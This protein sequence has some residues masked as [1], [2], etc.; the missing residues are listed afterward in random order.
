VNV[1]PEL[2][3][4][5]GK[6]DAMPPNDGASLPI[7]GFQH[8]PKCKRTN[9]SRRIHAGHQATIDNGTPLNRSA[10]R[11]D[12]KKRA[13]IDELEEVFPSTAHSLDITFLESNKVFFSGTS[14]RVLPNNH[15]PSDII[16]SAKEDLKVIDTIEGARMKSL[17][18]DSVFFLIPRKDAI[19]K[20]T[21]VNN[22]L[23]S[24]HALD[25]ANA[26]TEVRGKKRIAVAEDDGKYT[27]VGL[28]ANRASTGIRESWPK[29]FSQDDKEEITKLMIGCEEVANGFLPPDELR[30]FRAAKVLGD[31][32]DLSGAPSRCIFGSLASG[33]NH[34]LNTHTDEDFF[35]SVTTVPSAYGLRE[36]IDR[37]QIDVEVC[38]YFTFPEQGIAVALRPGDILLFNPQYQHCISSRTSIYETEDV[39]C[40]SLYLKS[41]VV[42][43]ND[44]SLP[45][46]A[47]DVNSLKGKH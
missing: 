23:S 1:P 10:R 8:V 19:A 4:S 21:Y 46:T 13:K 24:L 35:Y 15:P 16:L 18:G 27:T 34:Y 26:K 5:E 32:M 45:H 28:K 40:V 7:R 3:Y 11:R 14:M 17:S 41:A 44:N 29:M 31:W 43:K 6:V 9:S 42:G 47:T 38:N 39:F 37:Y 30:G 36:D 33:L 20:A 22:T 12:K 2:Y 25:Q